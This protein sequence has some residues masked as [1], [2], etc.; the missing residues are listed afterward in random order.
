[1]CVNEVWGLQVYLTGMSSIGVGRLVSENVQI[2][3]NQNFHLNNLFSVL[4][5]Q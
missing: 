3:K 1:M 4:K 5:S 2:R